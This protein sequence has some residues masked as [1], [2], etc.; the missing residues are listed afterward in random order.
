MSP[1][2]FADSF[3]E[4]V[5]VEVDWVEGCR[6]GPKTIEGLREILQKY[7]PAGRPVEISL[8]DEI[9][10]AEWD[11]PVPPGPYGLT[12]FAPGGSY[13]RVQRLVRRH[14]DPAWG[15]FDPAF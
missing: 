4:R 6:P 2:L 7:G 5:E 3:A 10:R 12:R 1:S 14:A 8:D 13:D 15:P 11:E 9:P